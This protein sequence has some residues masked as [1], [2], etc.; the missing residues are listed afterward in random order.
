MLHGIDIP[1]WVAMRDQGMRNF[2]ATRFAR[3]RRETET[4]LSKLTEF[5]YNNIIKELHVAPSCPVWIFSSSHIQP[6]TSCSPQ[7]PLSLTISALRQNKRELLPMAFVVRPAGLLLSR[8][9]VLGHA[10]VPAWHRTPR[11][12]AQF[13]RQSPQRARL[14]A[15]AAPPPQQQ[16]KSPATAAAPV[17]SASSPSSAPS[18]SP[19]AD[20]AIKLLYD[21]ECP[22]CVKEVNFLRRRNDRFAP[23][24]P[25]VFVDIAEDAY[26]AA[27]NGNID[28]ETAMG[29]IHGITSDGRVLVGVEVFR[30]VY[31][32]IGLGWVYAATRLPGV[33]AVVEWVYGI[34]A[35][36][37]LQLTGR[38][39]L[40]DVVAAREKRTCR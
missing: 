39:D 25:V 18:T 37:R 23:A 7:L 26:S 2:L 30:E 31:S 21:G 38:P 40:K 11:S 15:T 28:Y 4:N 24:T 13:T 8:A 16:G 14:L 6:S 3:R 33:G 34:W 36:R 20:F 17:P 35:D 19:G 9:R 32:A 12:P 22:L 1:N 5:I 29:R 10:S 27:D